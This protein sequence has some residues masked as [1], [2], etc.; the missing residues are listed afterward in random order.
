M[1]R[2]G[3]VG[4]MRVF[5]ALLPSRDAVADLEDFL[6]PRLDAGRAAGLRW[7]AP[8][9][10]HVT[11]A[12]AAHADPW[13]S[14]DVEERLAAAAGRRTPV[15]TRLAGGGAFPDVAGAKVVWAGLELDPAGAAELDQLAQGART[16]L[17][18]AGVEVDGAR[19]RPH[20]T[21]ARRTK[22]ADVTPWVQLLDGYR[23]PGFTLD[24]FLLV[25]SHLGEGPRGGPRHE[26]LAEVPLGATRG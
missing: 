13:R 26:T 4:R 7:S 24:R 5:V 21:L 3:P 25:A 6:E 22:P 15:E 10:W 17:S 8:G 1:R 9:Q 2:V 19:F 23:G 12:F 18:T 20:L 16:A 11:L 14:D